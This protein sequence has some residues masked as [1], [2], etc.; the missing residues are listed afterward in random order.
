MR[1]SGRS[2]SALRSLVPSLIAAVASL[3]AAAAYADGCAEP[4]F[5]AARGFGSAALAYASGTG[6]FNG[7]G[8]PDLAVGSLSADGGSTALVSILL[9]KGFASFHER[10]EYPSVGQIST[11]LVRDMNSD[12]V[13][14]LVVASN[15]TQRTAVLLGKGDG[16]FQASVPLDGIGGYGLAFGDL[17]GDGKE[18]AVSVGSPLVTTRLGNGDLTFRDGS[19][20]PLLI[21]DALASAAI[22]DV[23]GDGRID[24]IIG[25]N[26]PGGAHPIVVLPGNGDGS[27]G[28]P[29]ESPASVNNWLLEVGD[30]NDDG[31]SDV[32][33]LDYD[34]GTVRILLGQRDGT[35]QFSAVFE[36]GIHPR[37]VARG[38]FDGDSDL[39]LAV[40]NNTSHSVSV[41][42]GNG[43]GS[44]AAPV[45]YD[46]GTSPTSVSTGD[47]TADGILDLAVTELGLGDQIEYW[48]LVGNGDGTF[49]TAPRYAT[50]SGPEAPR[51]GDFDGDGKLDL[52][53]ANNFSNTVGVMLNRGDGSFGP[54]VDHVT[55]TNPIAL[56]LGD[57]NRDRRL[58]V[59]AAN[60]N[61]GSIALL[62]GNGDGG[63]QAAVP[64]A[65][66]LVGSYFVLAGHFNSDNNLD[67]AVT[68]LS[69]ATLVGGIHVFL[70]NGSGGFQGPVSTAGPAILDVLAAGDFNNDRKL[71][72]AWTETGT[73]TVALVLG[74]GNG[75]FGPRRDL[76]VGINVQDLALAD[77]NGDRRLD[78]ATA[79][80]GCNPC[81]I[82]D[83]RFR[84]SIS[85]LLGKGDGSF[86]PSSTMV[87][88]EKGSLTSIA[89]GDFNGDG[90]ADVAAT[91]IHLRVVS[92]LLGR[93]DGS[94]E[95]PLAFNVQNSP[96]GIAVGDLD[97]NG[98]FDLAV[99]NKASNS[100]SVLLNT[101]PTVPPPPIEEEP[102]LD[103][104][105]APA[106]AEK[107]A[108]DEHTVTATVTL[109]DAAV[110]GATVDFEV[111]S[112]PNA[113]RSGTGV[114]DGS[115]R[116]AF[117]YT[118]AGGAGTDA[119]R[120]TATSDNA[121]TTTCDA[122][123]AWT[124]REPATEVHDLA[125]TKLTG[126]K[127]VTLSDKR[128]QQSKLVK[129]TLQN[130]GVR[131]VTI[132]DAAALAALVQVSVE[133]LDECPSPSAAL[134][135]KVAA[136]LP[137][138][139]KPK[140][141]WTLSF[142]VIFDCANDPAASSNRAPGREDFRLSASLDLQ[143]LNGSDDT[144]PAD[145]VCPRAPS[146]ADKGC[147]AKDVATRQLGAAVLTDVVVK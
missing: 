113:G 118:G 70:G 72:I 105:L 97:G 42:L 131:S 82:P 79:N 24:V 86:E 35:L 139:L 114:T 50:G 14:D 60:L 67:F 19:T 74:A 123:V 58:D 135:P 9:G 64:A 87:V 89:A 13:P 94:F 48:V 92:V 1:R 43:D 102:R 132:P 110:S 56:A 61:T 137:R 130:R 101:C 37:A 138:T 21:R 127:R 140:Q 40:V 34:A 121:T 71:D 104:S 98:T 128:P 3:L 53:V 66:L 27:L 41:I 36:T 73:S 4:R 39:D 12:D 78:I 76:E 116:A 23:N 90:N 133:S 17:D 22:G 122:S 106:E 68:G 96:E 8:L 26:G 146:G 88:N 38:D 81:V 75:S 143:A 25:T 142:D 134:S 62:A 57:F 28:E 117:S 119:I 91:D 103:C 83:L 33:A 20:Y 129:V 59:L 99:A 95:P 46:V 145:N 44:F 10:V 80:L 109:D 115:G 84:G 93:G 112:G 141:S 6:D 15:L 108:G 11:T 69:G 136:G 126:I 47:F 45:S 29:I 32:A 54:R 85:V 31:G 49:Q 124:E 77:F 144:N 147:G 2:P 7:D 16:T 52:A 107:R 5:A 51:L 65:E 111:V 120:A 18:D 55:G 100:V 125:I 30:F 63:F